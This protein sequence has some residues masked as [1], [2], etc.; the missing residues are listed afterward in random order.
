MNDDGELGSESGSRSSASSTRN[1]SSSSARAAAHMASG[2]DPF[3][4]LSCMMADS[5][6]L[7]NK[8]TLT[9]ISSASGTATALDSSS[10]SSSA[11]AGHGELAMG[12]ILSG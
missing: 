2:S 8:G 7:F 9:I 4:L 3:S 6:E 12:K 10:T 5:P 11:L 1:S